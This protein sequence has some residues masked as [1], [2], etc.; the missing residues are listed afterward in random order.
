MSTNFNSLGI[1]K[2]PSDTNVVVAMS[3]GVDSSVTAALLVEEGYNVTGITLKLYDDR[4]LESKNGT[5]CAGADIRDARSVARKLNISHQIINLESNFKQSVIDNFVDSYIEGNTPIPCVRC[6]QTVK[7]ND[8]FNFAKKINADCLATG[9][10]V[11]RVN[12]ENEIF[13]QRGLDLSK[14]Q[15]YFMFATTSKQLKF[16]RFPLGFITKTETRK[17][18]KKYELTVKD[19]PDS[20]DICFVPN[21]NYS[22]L[23]RKLRP[24]SIEK[25]EIIHEDGTVL[26]K[27]NG[28]IDYT[29]GQ[30]RRLNIGGRKETNGNTMPLYVTNLDVEKNIVIVGPKE[31]LAIKKIFLENMNWICSENYLQKNK[32]LDGKN[33]YVKLRNSS[34]LKKAKLF[35]KKNNAVKLELESEEFGIASGQA[36]VIYD[37]KNKNLLL[38]GGWITTNKN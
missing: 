18:A 17:L 30:R 27:H 3:G 24:G 31:S 14:D 25:G 5:C 6:N 16:L 29:I 11:R 9:H 35:F 23:V 33:V 37:E 1:P 19:K 10:Y 32:F 34:D 4:K 2:R 7:F 36:G 20:Q 8:L 21:G 26:G 15:S 28:I 38:G 22:N 12:I 13:L